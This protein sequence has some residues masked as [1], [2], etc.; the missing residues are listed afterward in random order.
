MKKVLRNLCLFLILCVLSGIPMIV[1]AAEEP[2]SLEIQDGE[3]AIEVTL[4]GGSGRT[5]VAS[6]A[7][8]IVRDGEYGGRFGV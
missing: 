7:V 1:C 8:L 5:T 4:E 2:V 3:Y 6:P